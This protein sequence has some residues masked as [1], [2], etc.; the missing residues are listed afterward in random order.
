MLELR[1]ITTSREVQVFALG[2]GHLVVASDCPVG[3][4]ELPADGQRLPAAMVGRFALR[5]CLSQLLALGA[6]P[7]S[8]TVM[9]GNPWQP[10]GAEFAAGLHAELADADLPD[11]PIGG[12]AEVT[13]PVAVTACGVVA[14]GVADQLH[15]RRTLPGDLLYLIGRPTPLA[16]LATATEWLRPVE[17]TSWLRDYQLGDL[18]PCG[19]RGIRHALSV[20][21]EDCDLTV[22][23]A[24][25]IDAALL[26]APAWP[27]SC[28][29]L[30]T[31]DPL[32][33]LPGLQRLGSVD[34]Q[35]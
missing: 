31:P 17:L 10:V 24:G 12:S 23:I 30:S 34:D 35:E 33:D 22:K 32:P 27:A 11:L 18:L 20:L 7:S 3:L 4:G 29:V 5:T 1:P 13:A 15:W 2:K 8:L 26:D 19:P 25:R 16:A 21:A 14:F 9:V 6:T 28:A